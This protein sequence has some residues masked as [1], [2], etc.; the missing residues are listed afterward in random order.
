MKDLFPTRP[1]CLVTPGEAATHLNSHA[2]EGFQREFP[3]MT[4][5]KTHHTRH[6][7]QTCVALQAHF[8]PYWKNF[9]HH[10]GECFGVTTKAIEAGTVTPT[11]AYIESTGV[12]HHT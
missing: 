1:A 10:T 5:G 6:C 7:H 8:K 9:S 4:M 2:I 3:N 11:P 12:T